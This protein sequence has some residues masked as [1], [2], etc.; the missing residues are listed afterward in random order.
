MGHSIRSKIKRKFR[1]I[2]RDKIATKKEVAKQ[3][4]KE[5]KRPATCI[6]NRWSVPISAAF[7][8]GE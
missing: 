7:A 2:K 6:T 5:G 4:A 3:Q 1:A 8:I